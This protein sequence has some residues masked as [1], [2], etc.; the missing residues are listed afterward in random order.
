MFTVLTQPEG[1]ATV[2]IINWECQHQLT[3]HEKLSH[4]STKDV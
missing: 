3:K 4:E 2:V 1:T